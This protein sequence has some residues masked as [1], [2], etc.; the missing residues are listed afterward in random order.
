MKT[1]IKS[2]F[3]NIKRELSIAKTKKALDVI[4]K[5]SEN[6]ARKV[7]ISSDNLSDKKMVSKNLNYIRKL[8]NKISKKLT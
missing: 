5:N 3:S 2:F 7:N 4:V 1:E 6:F 8:S